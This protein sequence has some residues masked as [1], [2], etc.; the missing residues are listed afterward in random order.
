MLVHKVF[1]FSQL[2]HR[3]FVDFAVGADKDFFA[4]M[5]IVQDIGRAAAFV[6]FVSHIFAVF[7]GEGQ[8]ISFALAVADDEGVFPVDL[9]AEDGMQEFELFGVGVGNFKLA[10]LLLVNIDGVAMERSQGCNASELAAIKNSG[11]DVV[12]LH[13]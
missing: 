9:A 10:V 3:N 13:I 2:I 5:H 11:V 6:E 1:L 8:Q 12:E 7:V 4:V